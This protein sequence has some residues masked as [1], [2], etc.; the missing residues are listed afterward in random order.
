MT[1]L[2]VVFIFGDLYGKVGPRICNVSVWPYVCGVNVSTVT[3]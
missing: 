2:E 1:V 3:R